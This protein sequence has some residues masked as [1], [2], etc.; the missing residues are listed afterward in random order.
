[1][2]CYDRMFA[3]RLQGEDDFRTAYAGIAPL[4]SYDPASPPSVDVDN[5]VLN[6]RGHNAAFSTNLPKIAT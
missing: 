6:H 3:G 1:M 2:E 5:L 4:Y